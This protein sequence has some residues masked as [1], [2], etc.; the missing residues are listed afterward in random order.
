MKPSRNKKCIC[1]WRS[2]AGFKCLGLETLLSEKKPL[3]QTAEENATSDW[4]TC[5]GLKTASFAGQLSACRENTALLFQINKYLTELPRQTRQWSTQ[6]PY[7]TAP[8]AGAFAVDLGQLWSESLW[9]E[10]AHKPLKE[11]T[12]KARNLCCEM[13]APPK[14]THLTGKEECNAKMKEEDSKEAGVHASVWESK[15]DQVT[16]WGKETEAPAEP[17][18]IHLWLMWQNQGKKN[19]QFAPSWSIPTSLFNFSRGFL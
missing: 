15:Q 11:A 1:S 17:K 16:A 14:Q 13:T 6:Q 19:M 5:G 8:S 18:W 12:N 2:L 3:L 9:H 10:A 4:R 7:A